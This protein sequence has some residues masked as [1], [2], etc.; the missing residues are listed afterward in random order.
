MYFTTCQV[1]CKCYLLPLNMP[2][3]ILLNPVMEMASL[4]G[5][6]AVTQTG[7][8][9]DTVLIPPLLKMQ[10]KLPAVFI[11]QLRRDKVCSS[12][13]EDCWGENVKRLLYNACWS[14]ARS[15]SGA[16]I[17]TKHLHHSVRLSPLLSRHSPDW[18]EW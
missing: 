13:S 15:H 10:L 11:L 1:H 17:F 8:Q 3:G 5:D 9:R 4:Y 6:M 18:P 16:I 12:C 2:S 7:N 14:T